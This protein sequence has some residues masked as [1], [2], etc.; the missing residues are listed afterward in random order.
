MM[1]FF[2]FNFQIQSN[3]IIWPV[4]L[5]VQTYTLQVHWI[6]SSS[7]A[8][9]FLQNQLIE[10]LKL[11]SICFLINVNKIL[12]NWFTNN[13]AQ[14]Y[15]IDINNFVTDS[16]TH[17]HTHYLIRLRRGPELLAVTVC[18]IERSTK[19]NKAGTAII[20]YKSSWPYPYFLQVRN[21]SKMYHIVSVTPFLY[22]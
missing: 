9:V 22:V 8:N 7:L 18:P 17:T 12:Q 1:S 5:F 16:R 21:I 19:V 3:Y 4:I 6:A 10:I 11:N 13:Q 14:P 15:S 20:F 2:S